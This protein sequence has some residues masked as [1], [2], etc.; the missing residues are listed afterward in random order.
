VDWLIA[1]VLAAVIVGGG[2]AWYWFSPDPWAGWQT[3]SD[4]E[5]KTSFMYPAGWV[6]SSSPGFVNIKSDPDKVGGVKVLMKTDQAEVFVN[7][8]GLDAADVRKMKIGEL[9]WVVNHLD[10]EVP[11]GDR[12]PTST[13]NYTY[14]YHQF[15]GG[16]NMILEVIPSQKEKMNPELQKLISTVKNLP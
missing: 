11:G 6:I 16:R 4:A 12:F 5:N 10:I 14:F 15:A 8:L 7:A 2:L 9:D 3:Y 13:V 1:V